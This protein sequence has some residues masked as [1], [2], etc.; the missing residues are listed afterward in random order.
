[1]LEKGWWVSKRREREKVGWGVGES[2]NRGIY[3][4]MSQG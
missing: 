4:V 3:I 1:M 2:D